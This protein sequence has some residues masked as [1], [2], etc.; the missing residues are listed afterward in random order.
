MLHL[1][2]S[3][4][5]RMLPLP[6]R[7]RIPLLA[8]LYDGQNVTMTSPKQPHWSMP[9]ACHVSHDAEV[10]CVLM[11]WQGYLRSAVVPAEHG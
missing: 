7:V 11:V 5:V 9:P 1:E 4:T 10:L 2:R 3:I 6:G 8:Q